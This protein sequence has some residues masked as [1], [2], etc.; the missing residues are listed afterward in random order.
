MELTDTVVAIT[1][2]ARG[3]GRATAQALLAKGA[4][5]AIGDID[6]ESARTSAEE[7]ASDADSEVI[8]LPLDV[9]DFASFTD[10]LAAVEARFGP[11]DVLVNNAGIMPTGD[12]L[13]ETPAMT[14]QILDVNVRGVLN[15]SRLAAQRFA[16]RG[17]GHLV[18]VASLAGVTGEAG[19]ATYC[20]TKHFVVGFTDSL[21]RE[22]RHRGVG[23]SM[24]LPG[25]IDTELSAGTK[26]PGWAKPLATARPDDVAAGIVRALERDLPRVTVPIGLGLIL[27]SVAGLPDRTRLAVA[28]ALGFDQ[29]VGGADS[30]VRARYHE[31]LA[32]QQK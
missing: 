26:V 28:H 18:N 8:G 6:A 13:E 14:E 21:H 25:I 20:G 23:V 7:L 19:L 10:F 15:G 31:R 4:K 17:S 12:F 5:V 3:I 29:F 22:L 16:S 2:G 27:K 1:G 9:G 24:I 30:A 32:E 11:L